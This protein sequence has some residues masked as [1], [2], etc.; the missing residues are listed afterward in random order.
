[1]SFE[2]IGFMVYVVYNAISWEL[3]LICSCHKI[4]FIV[5]KC[6]YT[7]NVYLC[8][9]FVK[10]KIFSLKSKTYLGQPQPTSNI[11]MVPHT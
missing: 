5:V 2:N 11:Q 6:K 9:Y 7:I 3:I 1:M 10:C 4:E 8:I